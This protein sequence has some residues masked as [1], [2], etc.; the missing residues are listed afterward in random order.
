MNR[1]RKH[2]SFSTLELNTARSPAMCDIPDGEAPQK[3]RLGVQVCA[4][5][6]GFEI[7]KG[8]RGH[9]F[10]KNSSNRF[11]TAKENLTAA[12]LTEN[13]MP[14][15]YDKMWGGGANHAK[16]HTGTTSVA[17]SA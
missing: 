15:I 7:Y 10:I 2:P 9:V 12:S 5:Y 1:L 13:T 8:H 3:P 17:L 14:Y 16:C 11:V 4:Y 6:V